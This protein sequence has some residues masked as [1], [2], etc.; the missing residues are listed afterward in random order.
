[1]RADPTPDLKRRT[2]E[3]LGDLA[4]DWISLLEGI[5]RSERSIKAGQVVTHEEEKQ[6]M[7]RWLT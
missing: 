5:T 2:T 4:S 7:R 1:M 3:L 6:R